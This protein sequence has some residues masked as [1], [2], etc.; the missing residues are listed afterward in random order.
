M[1]GVRIGSRIGSV[2][3]S[4]I[5]IGADQ[6]GGAAE[7][8]ERVRTVIFASEQMTSSMAAV[9]AG[10]TRDAVIFADYPA[11]WTVPEAGSATGIGVSMT[12]V[13]ASAAAA[14]FEVYK[15]GVATG[16]T[17]SIASGA[18]RGYVSAEVD[19]HPFAADDALSVRVSTGAS[20]GTTNDA[21]ITLEFSVSDVGYAPYTV[22]GPWFRINIPNSLTDSVSYLSASSGDHTN[23]AVATRDGS[24]TGLSIGFTVAVA[25]GAAPFVAKVFKNGSEMTGAS[26][27][28]E[29]DAL[30]GY[31]TFAAGTHSFVAGD[32]LEVR[33]TTSGWTSTT[34]DMAAFIEFGYT[35]SASA[36]KVRSV[37]GP[38]L[39]SNVAASLAD[40]HNYLGVMTTH[41]EHVPLLRTGT[42]VAYC[43]QYSA[44]I[45]GSDLTVRIKKL[46]VD[47]FTFTVPVGETAV[48]S[49]FSGKSFA[50][51][52]AP[53]IHL[54][55]D[56]SWTGTPDVL[57]WLEAEG[58]L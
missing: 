29:A 30:T 8:G 16:L 42:L 11:F 49:T 39:G 9:A 24:V 48:R 22:V 27:T 13:N 17:V 50:A 52:E 47:E 33:I 32:Y 56:G 23:D 37:F 28:I 20:M 34:S 45:G 25:G 51:G 55:T 15:N 44:A 4:R 3:G 10:V 12:A 21:T 58:D 2:I 53:H 57:G 38:W 40:S 26:V 19:A 31:A 18:R 36:T 41:P 54:T 43:G 14:T 1:I 5:G 35:K 7:S 6:L 46:H